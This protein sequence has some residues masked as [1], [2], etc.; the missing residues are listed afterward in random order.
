MNHTGSEAVAVTETRLTHELHRRATS[1]LSEAALR[2]SVPLEALTELRTYLVK[3]LHHHHETEDE[4]LWPMIS[5][6]APEAAEELAALSKEH[7]ELDAALDALEVAPL[8]DDVDRQGLHQAAEAVRDLIHRHLEHEEP[9]LFPALEEYVSPESW[10]DFSRQVIATSP[11]EG[12]HLTVGFFDEVG[13][14]EEVALILSGLPA[15]AQQ[16]VPMMREQAR[17]SLAVLSGGNAS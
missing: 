3:N 4:V 8:R 10:T 5:S 2:P 14:P 12:A 9:I 7:D 16:F 1:L 13:T 11:M 6:V 17:A 15:P